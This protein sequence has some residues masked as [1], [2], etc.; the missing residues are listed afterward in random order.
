MDRYDP[1]RPSIFSRP[2][3][4]DL[5]G[6]SERTPVRATQ[7]GQEASRPIRPR[8]AG[9]FDGPPRV[10]DSEGMSRQ[11]IVL[12]SMGLGILAL[13]GF[14]VFSL[15]KPDAEP[16]AAAA[17]SASASTA[18][19]SESPSETATAEP[20]ASPIP[21]PEPTPAG[22]PTEVAMGGWAT[23]TVGE[24]NVRR[25][26][27]PDAP[28][29][30]RL[31]EGAIVHVAE[32]PTVIDGGNWYRVASLGGATGWASSGWQ[33]E[34]Y[35]ETVV[36]DPTL[37]RCGEVTRPVFDVVNGKPTPHDPLR[38]G[39]MALPVAAFSDISLGAMELLRGMG[40]EACFTAQLGNAGVP[41]VGTELN[42]GACGHTVAEGSFFRLRP[43][44]DG[45]LPLG[46]Q[47]R[48]PVV[49][50]PSVLD[51]GPPEDRK[52]SNIRTIVAM[53][54]NEGAAGC[55]SVSVTRGGEASRSVEVRQCSIVHE[56]NADSIKLT[57][58]S[59]GDLAWIKLTADGYQAGQF[60]LETPVHV[61]VNANAGEQGRAAYAWLTNVPDCR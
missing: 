40:Q 14:I 28:S 46:N 13:S 2:D 56:Y 4:D 43:A 25:N 15:L 58:A 26:A 12:G 32:G 49:V 60:P 61:S 10:R 57:L 7:P 1:D 16:A 9:E 37:I 33:S 36:D 35:L 44:A 8:P 48:D 20:T 47:I 45:N 41:V 34:P 42:V 17:P 50:H 27:G 19:Q 23:V 3:D 18:A 39:A 54:A 29:V 21:T 30:Y 59:G 6:T 22:P 31:V 51:G 52:S 24:L 5:D 55:I 53:M 38:I 11:V